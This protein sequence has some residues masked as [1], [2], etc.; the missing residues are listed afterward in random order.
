MDKATFAIAV[1]V[2]TQLLLF[3][4]LITAA[5]TDILYRRVYNWLTYPAIAFGLALGYA[6]D[7]PAGFLDRFV[8]FGIAFAIFGLAALG[9]GVKNGDWKLVCAIG[10]LSGQSLIVPELFYSTLVGAAI[11]VG[12]MVYHGR[13]LL[14]MKRCVRYAVGLRPEPLPESDPIMQRLPYAVAIAFGTFLAWGL[15]P[16]NGV[17]S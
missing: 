9:G 2:A 5:T 17:T 14:L 10:A 4:V 6:L 12:V 13:F 7:G 8:G 11:A 1:S 16:R 15:D 3:A